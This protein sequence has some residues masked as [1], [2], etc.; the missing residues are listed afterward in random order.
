MY[1]DPSPT[2]AAVA[3]PLQGEREKALVALPKNKVCPPAAFSAIVRAGFYRAYF[4]RHLS[5]QRAGLG[6]LPGRVVAGVRFHRPLECR[7]VFT[8]EHARG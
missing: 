8:A 6:R 5:L 1:L 7:Q 3:A 4:I 2:I